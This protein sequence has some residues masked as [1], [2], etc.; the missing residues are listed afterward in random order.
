MKL[1]C[2]FEEVLPWG[3]HFFSRNRLELNFDIDTRRH[4]ETAKLI[5]RLMRRVHNINNSLMGSDFEMLPGFLVCMRG[6]EHTKHL[7]VSRKGN[8]ANNFTTALAGHINE[9]FCRCIQ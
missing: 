4:V 8:W 5:H 9:L 1:D 3:R 2:L 7:S 6:T